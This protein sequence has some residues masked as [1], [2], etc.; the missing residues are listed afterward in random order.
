MKTKIL[1][2]LLIALSFAFVVS[3]YPQD[4]S[5]R[6]QKTTVEETSSLMVQKLHA[7]VMLS[8]EQQALITEL[9]VIYFQERQAVLDVLVEEQ[10]SESD[11]IAE[12]QLSGLDVL[13]KDPSSPMGVR[14]KYLFS[15]EVIME[16]RAIEE[17]YLTGIDQVLSSEQRGALT[18]KQAERESQ[19]EQEAQETANAR[20]QGQTDQ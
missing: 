6:E 7:D 8:T 20:N 1:K 19:A 14:T 2:S 18:S 13:T 15:E 16:L 5:Q 17:R 3:A 10:P 9:T 4:T 12:E 11:V